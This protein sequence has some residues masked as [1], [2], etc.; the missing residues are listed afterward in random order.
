MKRFQECN[1]L[2][3]VWRY[4]WYLPI[5]FQ[6]L[7]F[8]RIKPFKVGKD[9]VVDGE[10]VHTDDYDTVN[11][12]LLWSLLVGSAQIEMRW[13]HTNEEVFSSFNLD[14]KDEDTI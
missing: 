7:W 8:T 2:E 4:R 1:W 9:E 5:P 11:G 3:K 14:D 6:W 10:L 13:Y 12:K